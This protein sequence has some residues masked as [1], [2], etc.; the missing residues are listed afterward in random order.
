MMLSDIWIVMWKEMK[1][2]LR[3]KGSRTRSLLGLLIPMVMMGI[4]LPLQIGRALVEGPW[5][6]LASVFIPMMMGG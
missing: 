6:L 3:Y 4:Y 2:L 1:G 5:S